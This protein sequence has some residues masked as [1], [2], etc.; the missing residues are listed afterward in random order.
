MLGHPVRNARPPNS[1]KK[2][3]ACLKGLTAIEYSP[4]HLINPMGTSTQIKVKAV[5][6]TPSTPNGYR[7]ERDF[8]GFHP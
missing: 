2:I 5:A 6:I 3:A 4:N 8:R 1:K 7:A